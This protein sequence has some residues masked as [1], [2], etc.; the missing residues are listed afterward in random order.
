[1]SR[2]HLLLL[3]YLFI[4]LF[5]WNQECPNVNS[6]L[7]VFSTQQE[8][9][10]FAENFPNCAELDYGLI[11]T[12]GVEDLSRLSFLQ[13]IGGA[14]EIRNTNN[15]LSLQGLEGLREITSFL[16]IKNNESLTDISALNKVTSVSTL[17]INSNASLTA[18]TG[19]D[20][21]H[22][23]TGSLQIFS[24]EAI[25]EIS[26]FPNLELVGTNLQISRED[27]LISIIGFQ[28][29]KEVGNQVQIDFAD[30]LAY[31]LGFS[32]LEKVGSNFKIGSGALDSI[33]GFEKLDTIRG[34]FEIT[35]FPGAYA[36]SGFSNV[37]YI[38][39]Q[40]AFDKGLRKMEGFE[41]L[42]YIGTGFK[43]ISSK[44]LKETP[45]FP[46]AETIGGT[47]QVYNNPD[48][49][50]LPAFPAL[51]EID[52]AVI[53][54]ENLSLTQLKSLH[55]LQKING[56][57]EIE[58]NDSLITFDAFTNLDSIAWWVDIESNPSLISLDGLENLKY[59]GQKLDIR[60]CASLQQIDALARV[61]F[62]GDRV[63]INTNWALESIKG[64][65]S[66]QYIKDLQINSTNELETLEGLDSLQEVGK[67]ELRRHKKLKNI[68][69]LSSLQKISNGTLSII[70]NEALSDLSGLQNLKSMPD[71]WIFIDG[72]EN[73]QSIT[74]LDSLDATELF[75]LYIENN[76]KLR[77]CNARTVCEFIATNSGSAV[78]IR[79]N[80][81]GCNNTMEILRYC[82]DN[83]PT[84]TGKAFIDQ[85]CNGIQDTLDTVVPEVLLLESSTDMPFA[86]TD[87]SGIYIRGL[88]FDTTSQ[89]GLR[90]LNYFTIEPPQYSIMTADTI[91]L[92]DS[93]DFSL[94]PTETIRDLSTDL[95]SL[96]PPRPGFVHEYELCIRNT[97]T[98]PE[99][100]NIN[101]SFTGEDN[102]LW[103][104]SLFIDGEKMSAANA[105]WASVSIAPFARS[106]FN[107]S[108]YLI[109]DESILGE[110]LLP[111]AVVEL[112]GH[113]DNHP[114]DNI[115]S[116]SLS[117]VG[118]YDPNDKR[119]SIDSLNF[120]EV[121]GQLYLEY[122]IRFQ[123]TGTFMAEFI[124]V[125]DTINEAFDM[126]SFTMLSSSHN[127]QLKFK[128]DRLLSWFFP[129]IHLPPATENELASNGYIKFGIKTK[130]GLKIEDILSNKAYIYFDFNSPIITNEA[131][132]QFF[133]I[134]SLSSPPNIFNVK[135]YPNP[136]K[137]YF[138]V[139]I[140][141]P[142]SERE[143]DLQLFSSDGRLLE[144]RSI[145]TPEQ[146]RF[147]IPIGHLPPG[148][149]LIQLSIGG[150]R[151]IHKMIK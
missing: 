35:C 62:V 106:C 136:A 120:Q 83:L 132:T 22:S 33:G 57:L 107:I 65:Q 63:H 36:I 7:I 70:D 55:Q 87:S 101:L 40:L 50:Q 127:Y 25:R 72:N 149:Y 47:F 38:G 121:D 126:T 29:L 34:D 77:Y 68:H 53:I 51:S 37:R 9:E 4:P 12:Q 138:T 66:L 11:I 116:L 124:E 140:G 135:V 128:E 98:T 13:K 24:N 64:L 42:T 28:N 41:S 5:A 21:L 26:A 139:E 88:G 113:Q 19:F 112:I 115:D 59:I 52:G 79:N 85:N 71:G 82:T 32:E 137:N 114:A 119:V 100:A 151:T 90:S 8:V 20:S 2:D 131:T 97:G 84:V 117:I 129:D 103:I 74:A 15:L 80:A 31:I 76:R 94:C 125:T 67:L 130:S 43:I 69:A 118:S 58:R 105:S 49:Q 99:M 142:L 91:A 86:I 93:L 60:N 141:N 44:G 14:L 10:D 46:N 110:V 104:D 111:K 73:L 48:L 39:G 81:S 145:R 96:N 109:P 89:Y 108:V 146:D 147:T 143:V 148:I 122:T 123:N 18:L 56:Y 27:A 16:S 3:L 102:E 54:T 45:D 17:N 92:Y 133:T 134:T 95:I 144:Q 23:I 6:S 150:Q 1:M 61:N 30:S 75:R 78:T